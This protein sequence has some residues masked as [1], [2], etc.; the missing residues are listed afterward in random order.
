MNAFKNKSFFIPH[1]FP[2]FT[3]EYVA[4]VFSEMGDVK[5]VDFV[6]KRDSTGKMYNSAYVHF[7]EF[8]KTRAYMKF[9]TKMLR[10]G[11]VH[12]SHDDSTFYW[13]V[14]PN[15]AVKHESGDRKQR[16]DLG[17]LKAVNIR[18]STNPS[19]AD[20]VKGE[21]APVTRE[22]AYMTEFFQTGIS[23]EEW[24]RKEDAKMLA[25]AFQ[26][27]LEMMAELDEEEDVEQLMDEDDAHLVTIDSRY[28]ATLEK[29]NME[30]RAELDNMK[31][32]FNSMYRSS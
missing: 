23:V 13:I 1:V 10:D 18:T 20:K 19:Y 2:N 26:E 11:K 24:E 27:H 6:S 16:V 28:V 30:L 8:I 21:S 17:E 15:N 29:E 32:V 7:N 14:L 4:D 31:A 25:D 5:R 12:Y 9:E 22:E 3:K